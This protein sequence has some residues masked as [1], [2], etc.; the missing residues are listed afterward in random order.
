MKK[1]FFIIV[2]IFLF[3]GTAVT[4]ASQ[5]TQPVSGHDITSTLLWIGVLLIFAKLAG[6]IEKIGQPAVLGELVVGVLLGNLFLLGVTVFE[7]IKTNQFL[8]YAWVNIFYLHLLENN[9]KEV[10][11]I[12]NNKTTTLPSLDYM[13]F[14]YK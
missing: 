5:G 14:S 10:N 7:P 6:L 13:A 4:W 12:Y 2:V 9:K 3:G 11:N 1:T 8:I